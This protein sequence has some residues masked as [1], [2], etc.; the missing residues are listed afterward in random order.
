MERAVALA[1][2]HAQKGDIVSLSPASA[3]FDL[4]QTL[5]L[6]NHFKTIVKGL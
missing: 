1:K 2:E 3:S 4:Y 6:G 5:K